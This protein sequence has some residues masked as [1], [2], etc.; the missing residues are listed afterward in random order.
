MLDSQKGSQHP[1]SDLLVPPET[2]DFHRVR[3]LSLAHLS[4]PKNRPLGYRE[5]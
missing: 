5:V 3:S 4:H 2:D 1:P